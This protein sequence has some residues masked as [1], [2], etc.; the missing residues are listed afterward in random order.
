MG[1]CFDI[2]IKNNYKNIDNLVADHLDYGM[3]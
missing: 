3:V 1:G 2:R